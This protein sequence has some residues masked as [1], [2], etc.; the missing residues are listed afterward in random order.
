MF[1]FNPAEHAPRI[2]TPGNPWI[3]Q[4]ELMD[5]VALVLNGFARRCKQCRRP[6]RVKY[7]DAA[8]LCPDCKPPHRA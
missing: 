7:L 4:T 1:V 8:G 3:E 5:T 2:E 6:A